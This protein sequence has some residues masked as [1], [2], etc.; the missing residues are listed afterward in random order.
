L[1]GLWNAR[2]KM[3]EESA[4]HPPIVLISDDGH[5]SLQKS[6]DVL[7]L[8]SCKVACDDFGRV[9]PEVL[10]DRAEY[11]AKR[12][13][14]IITVY[15]MG[16]TFKGSYD[17]CHAHIQEMQT[18][19]FDEYG[20]P[21]WNHLDGA[22]GGFIIP[23][24]QMGIKTGVIEKDTQDSKAGNTDFIPQFGFDFDVQ[25]CNASFY[26]WYGA[27]YPCAVFMTQNKYLRDADTPDYIGSP[28]TTL[29]GGRNAFTALYMW[30]RLSLTDYVDEV[31]DLKKCLGV[32][33]YL[34]GNLQTIDE[35]MGGGLVE[36]QRAPYSLSVTFNS[37]S[38]RMSNKYSIPQETDS[39]TG[40]T[41][42]H[43]YAMKHV[44][45]APVDEF[46]DDY[47]KFLIGNQKLTELNMEW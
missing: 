11:Y 37:P 32:A 44:D 18:Q 21:H 45:E 35:E 26:K 16:T 15:N 46:C 24:L 9:R 10:F 2:E 33:E 3:D 30:W 29:G 12:D 47:R 5:Y 42:S 40:L 23:H 17:N 13:R 43:I 6:C 4:G 7:A 36:V 41:R 28:D 38:E 34:R 39:N 19:V 20:V 27:P 31:R 8:E 1:N 14:P 22:F 25:S